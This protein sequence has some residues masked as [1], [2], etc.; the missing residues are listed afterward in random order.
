MGD[1]FISRLWILFLLALIIHVSFLSSLVSCRRALKTW[2]RGQRRKEQKRGRGASIHRFAPLSEGS[3][4]GG[5]KEE[6]ENSE[7]GKIAQKEAQGEIQ[8]GPR[9]RYG[10]GFDKRDKYR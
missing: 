5:E 6:K 10:K 3:G 9:D 1:E 7:G 4:G 8:G 2:F